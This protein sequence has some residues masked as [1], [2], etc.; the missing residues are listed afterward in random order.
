MWLARATR[1]T[2]NTVINFKI[3]YDTV[4]YAA[5]KRACIQ[6]NHPLTSTEV[7]MR[8]PTASAAA[9]VLFFLL[10][11]D[12][13]LCCR[14]IRVLTSQISLE[15]EGTAVSGVR[16]VDDRNVSISD[17]LLCMRFNYKLL[18]GWEQRSQLMHIEDW[19]TQPGVIK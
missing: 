12:S 14:G 11:Y 10:L 18:G 15:E 5:I 19:R 16:L 9:A 17:I 1:P 2:E 4:R 6:G 3:D 7:D 8:S 13:N